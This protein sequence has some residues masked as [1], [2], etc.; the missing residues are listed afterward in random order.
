MW[1]HCRFFGPPTRG[2]ARLTPVG[3]GRRYVS[4][5]LRRRDV[6]DV[7]RDPMSPEDLEC[8][9]SLDAHEVGT[10]QDPR[11]RGTAPP[12]VRESRWEGRVPVSRGRH[13][14]RPP[15]DPVDLE[16]RRDTQERVDGVRGHTFPS[17]DIQEGSVASHCV[18]TQDPAEP[19]PRG[20]GRDRGL[21]YLRPTRVPGGSQ[22]RRGGR[23]RGF[24]TRTGV[25]RSVR[26]SAVMGWV[27]EL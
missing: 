6:P 10:G 8:L 16:S 2:S 17:A 27:Q 24:G 19:R 26:M 15:A 25:G 20:E 21:G 7:R 23:R 5:G 1:W 22:G 3:P 12:E 9:P 18:P 4:G 13:P 14:D 11:R